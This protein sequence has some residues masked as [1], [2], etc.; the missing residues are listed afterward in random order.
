M[1]DAQS[2]TIEGTYIGGVF[3]TSTR[4]PVETVYEVIGSVKLKVTEYMPISLSDG[5]IIIYPPVE[6]S[7][8]V[9]QE[10]VAL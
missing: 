9:N 4:N 2:L 7:L 1:S 10:G 8:N 3:I 5:L 6:F